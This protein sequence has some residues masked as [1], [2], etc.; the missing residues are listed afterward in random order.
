MKHL[1]KLNLELLIGSR[2][3]RYLSFLIFRFPLILRLLLSDVVGYRI[4]DSLFPFSLLTLS[5]GLLKKDL[6][7]ELK[8]LRELGSTGIDVDQA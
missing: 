5:A 7:L 8:A 4:K 1:Y 2:A 3:Y 6:N